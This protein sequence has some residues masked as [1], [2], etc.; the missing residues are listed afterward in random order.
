RGNYDLAT[1]V[2]SGQVLEP[3]DMVWMDA[4]CTVGGCRSDF[5]RAGVIGGPSVD[6]QDAQRLIWEVT[7]EG[8]RMVRP[9]VPVRDIAAHLNQRV[10]ALGLPMTSSVSG[11]AGR[12]GARLG[13]VTHGLPPM[14]RQRAYVSVARL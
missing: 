8:V 9:G 13:V 1:G 6:Q 3:G 11:R 7:M 10:A 14:W 4:G 5:G 2:G 12:G